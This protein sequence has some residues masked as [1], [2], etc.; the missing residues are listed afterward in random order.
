M[1]LMK[2]SIGN[3]KIV[4]IGLGYVG[5]PLALLSSKKGFHT[6]GVDLNKQK[7]KLIQ[8]KTSPFNDEEIQKELTTTSLQV[9]ND[10]AAVAS[11]DIIIL[12]VPTPVDNH[13]MPDYGPVQSACESIGPY[14]K[15]GQ[16]VILESTVNPGVCEEIVI[17]TIELVS[18]LR[19]GEDISVA[20]C[21]E[22]INPGDKKWNVSNIPRVIGGF[23][24]KSLDLA[25]EFYHSIID[26]EIKPMASL[27]E[28]EAVKIVEN[29]FRNINIAFV[30]ELAKSFA[31]LNIDVVNVINGAATKPFAFMPHYPG[32]GI[33]GHCIPVDPYYLIE[34]AFKNNGFKHDF[35]AL[36][37]KTNESMH[38]YTADLVRDELAKKGVS[39]ENARVAVLGLAYKKDIDDC[40]ESPSF[41]I[42]KYLQEMGA[43]VVSYDPHVLSK[44]SVRTLEEALTGTDAVV[45]AT[46]HAEFSG[47]SVNDLES[48]E[49]KSVID[50]RNCLKKEDFLASSISYKGVGR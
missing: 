36:A 29:S 12:C 22:R 28:A 21:P 17:P 19:V 11:A 27:K 10:F 14:L 5:L 35:L 1:S 34:Y 33:G 38:R 3:K 47:L 43:E 8:E 49:I 50:G 13:K 46:D 15:K 44:S 24:E 2:Q 31:R 16:C 23:D 48:F 41:G 26:A 37:C 30:N 9:S 40:R 20:H 18:K 4:V 39:I 42:I 25:V 7:I 6:T 45:V 32:C